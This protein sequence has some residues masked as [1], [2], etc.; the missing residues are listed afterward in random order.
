MA[1]GT[2]A[3]GE[4]TSTYDGTTCGI[5]T[6]GGWNLRY[7]PSVKKIN[8]TSTYGDTLIDGIY[9]GM[10]GVQLM[11]TFKEWIAQVKKAVWPYSNASPAF[12]GALGTIGKLQSDMAK[13]IVLT[14]VTGTPAATNGPTLFTASKAILSPDNDISILF[15]PDERN[16]PVLFDLLLYDDAGTKRFFAV[17]G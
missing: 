1:L 6:S 15:G 16:I 4:Y 17:T 13:A 3:V 14:P 12:D 5:V 8:D 11:V 7:R 2:F 10:T 9:R